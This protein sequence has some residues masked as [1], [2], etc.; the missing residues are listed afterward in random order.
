MEQPELVISPLSR[1]RVIAA[2]RQ[3][4]VRHAHYHRYSLDLVLTDSSV[5]ELRSEREIIIA[6][7][8]LTSGA[9]AGKNAFDARSEERA[10][11]YGEE[12]R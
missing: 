7:R 1:L 12:V 4:R 3:Q 9:H 11:M 5:L 10:I 6:M 2:L 8:C